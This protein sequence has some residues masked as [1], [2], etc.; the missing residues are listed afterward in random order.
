MALLSATMKKKINAYD[1]FIIIYTHQGI[2]PNEHIE[3]VNYIAQLV[4]NELNQLKPFIL[5]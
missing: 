5:V 3:I 2:E 1:K 4:Y